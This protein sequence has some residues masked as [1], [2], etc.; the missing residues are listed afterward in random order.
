MATN[1]TFQGWLG[2]DPDSVKG[3][4]KWG[5]FT[6]KVWEEDDVDIQVTH[7]GVCASD[8][9]TMSSGWGPISY[10]CCVGHEIVGKAVRVGNYVQHIK[11]G[12]R[13]GV[14]AQALSCLKPSCPE[15]S[16]GLKQ[17]C[18]G[19][20]NTYA[21]PYPDG[22]GVSYGGY[23]D[24]NRTNANF[25]FK[26][27]KG[28]AS[29]IAAP[30]LC[31]GLTVY[32]PL[33]QYAAGPGKSVGIVGIGGLGHFGIL[34]A[35][36][37][38]VDKV[39]AIS[40]SSSKKEDALQMGADAFV[41]TQEDDQWVNRNRRTLDLIIC[42]V[43]NEDQPLGDYL[44]LLNTRGTLVQ[45][46]NPDGGNLPKVNAFPLI[47]QGAKISGSCIG[48]PAEANEML[49]LAAE[50]NIKPWVI[51][52][53]MTDANQTIVDMGAGKAKYRYV[54]VNEKHI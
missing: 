27:P 10:P 22:K 42:T 47:V 17:H 40:R 13:V 31:G 5:D 1:Y 16:S 20:V 11:V 15:C 28:L 37:L 38:G 21:Q 51:S 43:G 9:H 19:F 4:M 25:V 3:E 44:W 36:A 52:R 53:P 30:M 50:K 26:I 6:P 34:F 41:A 2:L 46:G 45:V 14:G 24:Y 32:S 49:Q 8:L 23:S 7:C 12:D 33:K 29:E 39:V 35:K 18:A 48:S 54:L